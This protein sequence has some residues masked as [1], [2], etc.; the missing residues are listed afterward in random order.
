M[1]LVYCENMAIRMIVTSAIH[2]CSF[3]ELQ[4]TSIEW[5]ECKT[6]TRRMTATTNSPRGDVEERKTGESD[7]R[8]DRE[9]S[10]KLEHE[11]HKPRKS[12]ENLEE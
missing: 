2:H 11:S 9:W 7:G 12:D 6:T 1:F 5:K 8:S 4:Q 3:A 10:N